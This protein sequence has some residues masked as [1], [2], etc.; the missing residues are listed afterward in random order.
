M[1]RRVQPARVLALLYLAGATLGLIS[2]LLPHPAAHEWLLDLPAAFGFGVGAAIYLNSARIPRWGVHVLLAASVAMVGIAVYGAGVAGGVYGSM[3]FWP[4]VF[5]GLFFSRRLMF[6]H[7]GWIMV[8]YTVDQTQ[9]SNPSG[10]SP[11]T[12]VLG[13]AVA[14]GLVAWVT[15]WITRDR[16]RAEAE[17]LRLVSE[18]EALARTDPLTGLPNRRAWDEAVIR[19]LARARRE[20]KGL[21]IAVLDVDD[22]KLINDRSGHAAGD[23]L[24]RATS[25][26][27]L[28][29]LRSSDYLARIGGDEFAVLLPD[30]PVDE[31]GVIVGRLRQAMDIG[32]TY[33][34]GVA[35]WDGDEAAAALLHR[36]DGALYTAKADGRDRLICA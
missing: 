26:R 32:P 13:A 19:E 10:L 30:C 7:V 9:I 6:L 18:L 24:L 33:S 28:S 22:L 5:A 14:V 35:A 25:A 11:V 8:V 36:A 34:A 1:D 31:A 27:W 29:A 16:D 3:F 20:R 15:N 12:R 2:I 23:E 4:A 21:C 17:R